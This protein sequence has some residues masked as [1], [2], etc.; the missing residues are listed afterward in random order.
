MNDNPVLQAIDSAVKNNPYPTVK[1]RI[2]RLCRAGIE[3]PATAPAVLQQIAKIADLL[4][5]D[6][7]GVKV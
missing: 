2:Q 7:T 1:D 5:D 3:T 4:P 6:Y